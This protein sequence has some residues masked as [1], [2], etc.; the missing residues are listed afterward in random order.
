M[1]DITGAPDN[2]EEGM[3]ITLGSSVSDASPVD[4]AA[5]FKYSYDF[6]NDGTFDSGSGSIANMQLA[7]LNFLIQQNWVNASGGYCALQY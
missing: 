4:T 7:G 1:A 2:I 5:G 3:P 6:N